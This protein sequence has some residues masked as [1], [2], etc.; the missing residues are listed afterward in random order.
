MKERDITGRRFGRLVA[1]RALG[2]SP[3]WQLQ[4]ECRCDCG[5][6]VT[7]HKNNLMSGHTRSCGCLRADMIR[8]FNNG[9]N[10]S[11]VG[12]AGPHRESRG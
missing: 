5:R 10:D 3:S 2:K 1:L 8:D 9:K 12:L 4:W 6:I 11:T 7:V